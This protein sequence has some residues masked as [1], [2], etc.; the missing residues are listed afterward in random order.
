[1]KNKLILASSSPRRKYL[2]ENVGIKF[3]VVE[4]TGEEEYDGMKNRTFLLKGMPKLK[5]D[6]IIAHG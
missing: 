4:P 1:M 3:R 2:L 5:S 6:S